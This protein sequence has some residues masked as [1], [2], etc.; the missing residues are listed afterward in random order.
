VNIKKW[1]VLLAALFSLSTIQARLVFTTIDSPGFYQLSDELDNSV[2]IEVSDVT[3]D[4]NGHTITAAT[5]II[6]NGGL[7][8]ITIMNG[9]IE[10]TTDGIIANA[11]CTGITLDNMRVEG[12]IRGINFDTVTSG[13]IKNCEMTLNTTGL[14]LDNS[15][16]ITVKDCIA[17]CNTHA[18]YDLISSF[19]NCFEN[20][21]A[22][23]TGEGN[24]DIDTTTVFGFVSANG[25]GNIF[26]RCIAN[27][28][29]AL[30]V[31]GSSSLIAG[32]ALRGSEGCTKIIDSESANTQTYAGGFTVPYGILLEGTIDSTQNVTGALTGNDG[33]AD[34]VAWSPDGQYIAVFGFDLIG[35]D[36]QIFKFNPASETL[37]A[38]TG[39]LSTADVGWRIDWSPDGLYLAVGGVDLVGDDFQ[40]FKFDRFS[41]TLTNLDIGTGITGQTLAVDWSPDGLYLAV[42]GD[43]SGGTGDGFQIFKFDSASEAITSIT[44]ALGTAGRLDSAKWSPDGQ[45]LAVGGSGLTGGSGDELQIFKFDRAAGILTSITGALGTAGAVYDINWSPDGQYIT[46]GGAGLTGGSGDEFQIFQFDRAA[47]TVTNIAGALSSAGIVQSV[48]W[49]PDGKYVAVGG[50]QLLG[51]GE[52]VLQ[53]FSG[54]QFPE[55]N[56]IKGNTVYCNSGAQFPSGVGISAPSITNMVIGNTAFN[57]PIPRAAN[58]PIVE[59][60]Y[61]F[62]TN[63]FNQLFGDAPTALQNISLS[64]I[65]P[66]LDRYDI[67]GG[68]NRLEALAESLIDNLL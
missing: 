59:T 35:N 28:T 64:G 11:G 61:A 60:N 29:Q 56:V 65:D 2:T 50:Y 30:S 17:N 13:L 37:T 45:Y 41:E 52:D 9:S 49:S 1:V 15:H 33:E 63:V 6:I 34:G 3:F 66:V 62:V 24:T 21:K 25:R 27:S 7:D 47:G 36:L 58:L 51:A 40:I 18:G 4:L 23:S 53:I 32:F 38:I 48:P 26:E 5:G 54:L 57:N 19:T 8:N 44:G 55:K 67:P 39:I 16:K 68:L 42:G 43:L 10:A 22:L 20:C 14:E 31:T 12:A 46:V